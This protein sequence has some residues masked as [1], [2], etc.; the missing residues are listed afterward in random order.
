M[1]KDVPYLERPLT[2][3]EKDWLKSR[4]QE[5]KIERNE[6]IFGKDGEGV[7]AEGVYEEPN[8]DSGDG[9][10]DDS[11]EPE[12]EPGDSDSEEP[13]K[14]TVAEVEDMK[15]AELREE[16]RAAG[17]DDDGNKDVLVARMI[18]ALRERGQLVE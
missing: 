1:S 17:L 9:S 15:V 3:D 8:A 4:R 13:V 10:G 16:L 18:E 12:G 6:M 11:S 7:L 5:W 14:L 2:D